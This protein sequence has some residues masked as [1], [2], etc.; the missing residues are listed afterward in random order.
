VRIVYGILFSIGLYIFG[1]I[2]KQL[3]NVLGFTLQIGQ[4]V[5][6]LLGVFRFGFSVLGSF[7][8]A[9]SRFIY[10]GFAASH[11]D[12]EIKRLL[13]ENKEL[14]DKV[15]RLENDLII[16]RMREKKS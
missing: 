11:K 7:I 4:V 10:S 16:Y 14:V 1:S 3:G 12:K 8:M 2:T 15:K 6:A 9:L 13:Q 5:K